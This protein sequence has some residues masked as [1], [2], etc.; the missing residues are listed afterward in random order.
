MF[1][2][3]FEAAVEP[4]GTRWEKTRRLDGLEMG[5]INF[6]SFFREDF[7]F[8]L[9]EMGREQLQ[10]VLRAEIGIGLY[11]RRISGCITWSALYS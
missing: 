8:G 2:T 1:E 9:K 10:Q 6:L 5:M 3:L 7:P 11:C 4:S